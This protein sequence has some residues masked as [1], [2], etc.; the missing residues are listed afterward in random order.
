[1]AAQQSGGCEAEKVKGGSLVRCNGTPASTCPQCNDGKKYCLG[2][3]GH[4]E[5]HM[6]KQHGES[7]FPWITS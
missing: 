1:M 2:R 5:Q 4:Y 3:N 7:N 6:R